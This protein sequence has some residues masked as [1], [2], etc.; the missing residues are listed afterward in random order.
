MKVEEFFAK[1]EEDEQMMG[2][3]IE[4]SK[5]EN[6]LFE[7]LSSHGV[8]VVPASVRKQELSDEEMSHVAG[9]LQRQ[10]GP[11][12]EQALMDCVRTV[13]QEYQSGNVRSEDDL[14]LLRDKMKERKGI[15][16]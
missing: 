10:Q 9:I 13:Q 3:I 14:L 4:A 6:T 5:D 7:F 1:Y 15:K 16:A 11:V 12:S 8:E 2:Q